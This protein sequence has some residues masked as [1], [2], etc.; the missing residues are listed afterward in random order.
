MN[1]LGFENGVPN[2]HILAFEHN[3]NLPTQSW[4]VSLTA[5]GRFVPFAKKIFKF[6]RT[7][8]ITNPSR[9]LGLNFGHLFFEGWVELWTGLGVVVLCFELGVVACSEFGLQ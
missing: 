7:L 4:K 5:L 3:E 6:F 2:I 1:V 9:H 8:D